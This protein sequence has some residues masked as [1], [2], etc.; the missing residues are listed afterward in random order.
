MQLEEAVLPNFEV[1]HHEQD[2]PPPKGIA[3]F[4]TLPPNMEADFLQLLWQE[5]MAR[6]AATD[7][8]VH[9]LI[10]ASDTRYASPSVPIVCPMTRSCQV[11]NAH[12]DCLKQWQTLCHCQD[13]PPKAH[14]VCIG[15]KF[16][17]CLRNSSMQCRCRYLN[18]IS[19]H[20]SQA[21]LQHT[22]VL[23]S[24]LDPQGLHQ[25]LLLA[26]IS[27]LQVSF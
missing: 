23:G 12:D 26:G 2:D 18:E 21:S 25:A 17:V 11:F 19:G 14:Q 9:V 20:L 6:L 24:L 16:P 13:H 7:N 15:L 10:I 22:A 8:H 5:I 4:C 27:R 1:E 3:R